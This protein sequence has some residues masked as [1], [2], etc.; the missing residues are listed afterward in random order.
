MAVTFVI[1]STNQLISLVGLR[2]ASS[3]NSALANEFTAEASR[4]ASV[5]DLPGPRA[6]LHHLRELLSL[7]KVL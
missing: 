7:S 5:A 1:G 4:G 6:V 3:I 2:A